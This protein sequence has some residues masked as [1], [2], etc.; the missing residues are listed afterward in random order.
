MATEQLDLRGFDLIVS[1]D[2]G[3]VRGIR[4]DPTAVH[5]CYCH[6]PMCYLYDGYEAY[7][8][9]MGGITRRIF[10]ATAGRVRVW[11]QKAA[12]RVTHFI[13]NS[14]YVAGRIQRFYHRESTVIYPP[15]DLQ[16][17]RILQAPAAHYLCAGRLVAYK[18]TELMIQACMRLGRT[19]HIAGT[20]PEEV[21][22]RKL[23]GPQAR[24]LPFWGEMKT[25]ALWQEYAGC[26]AL[27]FAADED[28]GMVPWRLRHVVGQ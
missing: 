12:R 27:L 18:Q 14:E 20:G 16:R 24:A 22:L 1:S 3:P 5:I 10:S 11:D 13:A 19:L 17:A 7:R 8:A 21:R 2:S 28:F 9:Q 15:I 26:R 25:E 23:A 6:S 4:T